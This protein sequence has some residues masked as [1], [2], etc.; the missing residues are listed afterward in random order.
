[1]W[2]SFSVVYISFF[3]FSIIYDHQLMLSILFCKTTSTWWDYDA[4]HIDEMI[5]NSIEK[6]L[7]ILFYSHYCGHC[8]GLP[9][10]LQAY[11]EGLGNRSDIYL[12]KVDCADERRACG[13]FQIRG[14][15]TML[16]IMGNDRDYWPESPERGAEGWD[17]WIN[18]SIAPSVI[19]VRSFDDVTPALNDYKNGGS[20]FYLEVPSE[21]H[22]YFLKYKEISRTHK[23]YESKFYYALGSGPKLTGYT[24]KFCSIK[25]SGSVEKMEEFI[26]NN[27]FSAAHKFTDKELVDVGIRK[28]AAV[29]VTNKDSIHQ[30]QA[31]ALHELTKGHCDFQYGWVSATGD[32]A[33]E[34]HK[35][36]ATTHLDLPCIVGIGRMKGIPRVYHGQTLTAWSSGFLG[37]VRSHGYGNVIRIMLS[38][39]TAYHVLYILLVILVIMLII[40]AYTV[41]DY[42]RLQKKSRKHDL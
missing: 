17:R 26:T 10:G 4:S 15:P 19:R 29:L 34:V 27:K 11:S 39:M 1:M 2:I 30:V 38:Q 42:V 14:T 12:S 3:Q 18:M 20:V 16:L 40:L 23:F 21:D 36:T 41:Y 33:K 9:E 7:F 35:M 5:K 32:S 25:F 31:E 22:P 24:S 37:A 8:H 28:P 13:K 6:P